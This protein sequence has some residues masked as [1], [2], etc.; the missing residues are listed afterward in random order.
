MVT[1]ECVGVQEAVDG[2][3]AMVEDAGDFPVDASTEGVMAIL[4]HSHKLAYTSFAPLLGMHLVD[5]HRGVYMPPFP[6]TVQLQQT[7]LKQY[8]QCVPHPRCPAIQP[9]ETESR[10]MLL[11]G[12]ACPCRAGVDSRCRAVISQGGNT[13][14]SGCREKADAEAAKQAG[15]AAAQATVAQAATV[16]G[17][18]E[19]IPIP[20]MPVGWKPG[21]PIIMEARHTPAG[22]PLPGPA[23]D[24]PAGIRLRH[25]H[26]AA[27]LAS[28]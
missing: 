8:A 17:G 13:S 26:F 19:D 12:P 27:V 15:A 22:G 11:Q 20:K 9:V 25:C 3:R 23:P 7:F 24:K 18:L 6:Q 14:L 28:T 1:T 4:A 21:D 2:A 10:A 5:P 16:V